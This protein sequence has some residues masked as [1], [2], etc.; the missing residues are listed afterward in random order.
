[1][2]IPWLAAFKVIPWREVVTA[3]PSIL[4][5]TKKLW[6]T[7]SRTEEQAPPAE[8]QPK[9]AASNQPDPLLA[10]NARLRA[11]ESRTTEIAREAVSSADLMRSLAEQN[12]Q[13]VQAVEILRLRTR[14]S[15]WA[16]VVLGLGGCILFLWVILHG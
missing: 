7:V 12:A 3:A 15:I 4:E 16:T 9:E 6:N 5:G 2:A 13:L 10:I 11:L 14:R 1:M 8:E